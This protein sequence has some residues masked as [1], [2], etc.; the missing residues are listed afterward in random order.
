M[1]DRFR[2]GEGEEARLTPGA[3]CAAE[4]W[5]RGSL[6]L[7]ARVESSHHARPGF[8]GTAVVLGEKT[9]EVVSETELP[10]QGLVVYRLHEWPPGEVVRDRLTYGQSL[11][12]AAQAQRE[13]N[14]DRERARPFRLLLYPLVGLLPEEQQE[15][16]CDR[17]GLYAVHA[18]L[19]SG[20][21]ESA[22]VLLALTTLA[23]AGDPGRSIALVSALPGLVLLAIPGLG[24]AF[25][26][27]LLRETA[28]SP[29]VV[30]AL[31]AL[32]ALRAPSGHVDRG[33]LPLTRACFWERLLRPDDVREQADGTLVFRGLLPHLGWDVPRRLLFAGHYWEVAASPPA[34]HGG[35]LR[36]G[37][38][39]AALGTVAGRPAP[40]L[41]PATAY[42][43]EVKDGV[44]R[45]WDGWN[46]GF[47]W[48]TSLFAA[49]VQERAFAHRRGPAGARRATLAS[50]GAC[51]ALGLYLLSFLP[52]PPG[53]PLAPAAAF[54]GAGLLLDA[55][56]RWGAARAGRY[57]PSL[58]R[59]LLPSHLLR[60][61]R[62]AYQAH[63]DAER[64]ALA[65]VRR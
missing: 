3:A 50:A 41:P 45:E 26:A 27:A 43:D 4:I 21:F 48:L 16:L 53:D 35:Q 36:Y 55:A 39:L 28:G 31:A 15:R 22:L 54:L 33:L 42:V 47:A 63:R 19:A 65:L 30:L 49:D 10:E 40:G 64:E 34:L 38:R 57:A 23:R 12:R 52:G 2:V 11:V 62:L 25:G 61:E 60:P 7:R 1:T 20:L 59:F 46:A 44:R 32:R 56:R 37:Y 9:Y 13:A 17:L 24:R 18:T 29:P 58:F 5:S 8:P 14:R 6:P 51:G